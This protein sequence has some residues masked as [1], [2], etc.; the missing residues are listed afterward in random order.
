MVHLLTFTKLTPRSNP[1]RYRTSGTDTDSTYGFL[2]V[3]AELRQTDLPVVIPGVDSCGLRSRRVQNRFLHYYWSSDT[4][5]QVP[6]PKASLASPTVLS[7]HKH[8]RESAFMKLDIYNLTDRSLLCHWNFKSP[9]EHHIL[10]P[11][12]PTNVKT[13]NRTSIITLTAHQ[14]ISQR[15]QKDEIWLST[16][17]FSFGCRS[18]ALWKVME[19]DESAPWMIYR[20]RV[21]RD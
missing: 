13:P 9:Q 4:V 3:N 7:T 1:M 2:S 15:G 11:N 10:L 21:S 19:L 17:S 18:S 8:S 6:T 5:T 20:S 16:T 14:S 12:Q